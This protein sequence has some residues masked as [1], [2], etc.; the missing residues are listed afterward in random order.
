[1]FS[2]RASAIAVFPVPLFPTKSHAQSV[3]VAANWLN[4]CFGFSSPTKSSMLVGLYFSE[5]CMSLAEV[6]SWEVGNDLVCF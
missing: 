5:S 2:A 6:E 3:G 1:M 4:I